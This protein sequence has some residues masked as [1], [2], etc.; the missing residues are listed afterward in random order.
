MREILEQENYCRQLRCQRLYDQHGVQVHDFHDRQYSVASDTQDATIDG[1]TAR[2]LFAGFVAK[3][4]QRACSIDAYQLRPALLQITLSQSISEA[5]AHQGYIVTLG[6]SVES[7]DA[8]TLS[9]GP[10]TFVR[11][12]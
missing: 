5:P 3:H 12:R 6:G 4:E 9:G 8:E 11:A 1:E 10:K 7:G 2:A